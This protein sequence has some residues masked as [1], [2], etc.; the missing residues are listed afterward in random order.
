MEYTRISNLENTYPQ[1]GNYILN[2]GD[3]SMS[4]LYGIYPDKNRLDFK[5]PSLADIKSVEG[6]NF[7]FILA[8]FK[9]YQDT[10][11]VYYTSDK[12]LNDL[13]AAAAEGNPYFLQS[14]FSNSNIV[15]YVYE[16]IIKM[17][18]SMKPLEQKSRVDFRINIFS[19]VSGSVDYDNLVTYIDWL[20]D[21]QS[22]LDDINFGV[23]EPTTISG[24]NVF[25]GNF[26]TGEVKTT[27][28]ASYG[29]GSEFVSILDSATLD[30]EADLKFQKEKL[31]KIKE[32]IALFENAIKTKGGYNLPRIET[33]Y[34]S[35]DG[36]IYKARTDVSLARR[37]RGR[38]EDV[39]E[40]QK[41]ITDRLIEE[42]NI[43]NSQKISAEQAVGAA[44]NKFNAAQKAAGD[45]VNKAKEEI[46][47]L[48]NLAGDLMNKIP[49]I[50]KL[51]AIPKIPKL[52]SLTD[53]GAMALALLPVLPALPKLPSLPK[54]PSFK[55]P[56][57]KLFKPKKPKEPK[58]I[59]KNKGK[60][61]K[62]ALGD[63]QDAANSAQ[64]AVAGAV[65]AAAGAAAAAVAVADKAKSAA[66]N[67]QA[68]V[69]NAK[70]AVQ[71]GIDN[72]KSAAQGAVDNAKSTVQGAVDNI[73]NNIPK[74]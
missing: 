31:E 4:N 5:L 29:I 74:V 27:V 50:P 9:D 22:P 62:G 15:S 33:A 52:P 42:I 70:A 32:K 25:D 6:T 34:A 36:V 59:K 41:R 19:G 28:S 53:L 57:L 39:T 43:L 1:S 60:G 18:D 66:A 12:Y 23:L 49:K 8:I 38:A 68:A 45:A 3:K 51:P 54:K 48:K 37:I 24:W 73:K 67:A 72:A 7:R 58:K 17:V 10:K 61:L 30:L 64:G 65:A 63:L 40:R 71:S 14:S 56:P 21:K 47:K 2:K 13:I 55:L 44:Q 16:D 35:L 26:A 11:P 69:D 46:D 20:V